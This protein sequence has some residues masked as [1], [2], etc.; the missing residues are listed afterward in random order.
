MIE[1]LKKINSD[2]HSE[3]EDKI[4][5]LIGKDFVGFFENLIKIYSIKKFKLIV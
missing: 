1:E 3:I 4:S 5:N 2:N